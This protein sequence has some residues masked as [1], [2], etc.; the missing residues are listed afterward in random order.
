MAH[1]EIDT[2]AITDNVSAMGKR[3]GRDVI[4]V[5]KAGAYGHGVDLAAPAALAGGAAALA[6]ADIAEAVALRA[7]GFEAPLIAWLH[8]AEPRFDLAFEHDVQVV[9]SSLQQLDLAAAAHA[10]GRP[11]EV[12][13]KFDTGLGRN[14]IPQADWRTVVERADALQRRDRI[15]VVGL[16]SHLAGTSDD[17]DRAQAELFEM[18]L[19]KAAYLGAERTHLSA[20]AG[21]LVLDSGNTVRLGIAAYGLHPQ[22]L[23]SDGSMA[24]EVGLR[25]ALRLLGTARDGVLDVGYR[26]GL[27]HA[28]GISVLVD[29]ERV[30]VKQQRVDST[31]LERPVTGQAVVIGDPAAGEPGAGEWAE[32]VGTINYEIV[33]RLSA[34][35]ERRPA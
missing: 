4:V 5:V 11:G 20:S 30:A 22:G 16:M 6:T 31:V 17:A 19:A 13:L 32:R 14:G 25:P 21:A 12:H 18:L 28:P 9:A 7:S 35:L 33:T 8:A 29:G 15:R 2:R 3:T 23:D 1:I 10:P 26:D 27:L 24:R 34:R